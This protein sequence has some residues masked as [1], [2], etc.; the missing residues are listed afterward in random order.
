[1]V[2]KILELQSAVG[3]NAKQAILNKYSDDEPFCKFLY[4]A[5]NPML[6]YNLSE[7]TLTNMNKVALDNCDLLYQDIFECWQILQMR[8]KE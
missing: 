6:T 8:H 7:K 5:L 4:F 3:S 2:N 1:M